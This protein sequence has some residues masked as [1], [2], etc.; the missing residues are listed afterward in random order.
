M[1]EFTWNTAP[2]T[3]IANVSNYVYI[4][5]SGTVDLFNIPTS[6]RSSNISRKSSYN[7]LLQ[8]IILLHSIINMNQYGDSVEIFQRSALGSIY[9]SGSTITEDATVFELDATAGSYYYGTV[10]YLPSGGTPINLIQD[11]RMALEDGLITWKL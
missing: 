8:F 5:P 10:N 6:F 7:V 3:L 1:Y 11:I 2:L 4:N 9:V